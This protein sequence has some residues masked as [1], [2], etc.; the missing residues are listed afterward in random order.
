MPNTSKSI[1][2]ISM[3]KAG[4]T[5]V[6]SILVD[7]CT[8]HGLAMD[9]I[10]LAVPSSPL[11][12][13]EIFVGYQD[14]MKPEGFYYGVARGPYVA[15]MPVLKTLKVIVQVRDPRDCITSAYFSFRQSHKP[16]SDPNKREQFMQRREKLL[17]LDINEYSVTQANSY[18]NRLQIFQDIVENHPAALLVK[19]EDM[20]L[21]TEDWLR[22]ISEFVGQPVNDGLR[23]ALGDKIDFSVAKEDPLRH[24]RQVT[25]GDHAR[26]L[27]P[28]AIAELN[29][30]IGNQMA[31]FGYAV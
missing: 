4:S 21:R 16:P 30:R 3:H 20:V 6:D 8:V 5:I 12:E 31:F 10:S 17:K 22:Q 9:R 23:T 28:A 19:Y 11:T 2:C 13:A 24:K 26:K 1:I 18:R 29:T 15:D 27:D 14:K 7:I 25:P